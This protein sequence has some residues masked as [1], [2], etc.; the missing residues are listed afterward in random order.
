MKNITLK[1]IL[2]FCLLCYCAV[3]YGQRQQGVKGDRIEV[4]RKKF[5]SEKL[6][7]SN[8]QA[9]KFWPEYQV[10]NRK[11]KAIRKSMRLLKLASDTTEE[12]QRRKLYQMLELKQKG[13]DLEKEYLEKFLSVISVKQVVMLPMTEKE[14]VK[15][16]RKKLSEVE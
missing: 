16:L 5:I 6:V 12:T 14:F 10:Y 1:P 7:L 2:F 4:A 9:A 11:R 15:L 3:S 13:L 8:E